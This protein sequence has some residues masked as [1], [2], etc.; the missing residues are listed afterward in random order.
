MSNKLLLDKLEG[1]K[2][3]YDEVSDLISNPEIITDMK[4]YIQLNKEYRQLEPLIDQ[5]K[6]YKNLISN[7]ESAKSILITEKDEEF[8]EMAKSE[9]DEFEN[10]VEPLEHEIK[11]LLLPADP[12]DDKMPW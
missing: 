9:L 5:L 7:I 11:I 12:E 3:R 10:K 6:V 4:R 2:K 1:I 8:R